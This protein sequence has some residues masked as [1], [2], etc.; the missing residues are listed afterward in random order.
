MVCLPNI[1]SI[2]SK[3]FSVFIFRYARIFLTFQNRRN[4]LR[5]AKGDIK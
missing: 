4:D 1:A 5:G 3:F 2:F